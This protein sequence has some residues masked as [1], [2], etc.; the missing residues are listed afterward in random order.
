MFGSP[1]LDVAIGMVFVYL[2]LS[3]ICS[4]ANELIEL[5][6][7]GRA[8]QLEEG[9]RELLQRET[10]ENVIQRLYH[11]LGGIF[12]RVYYYVTGKTNTTKED[13]LVARIYDHPL[14]NSLFKG[15]YE[16]NSRKLPSYIPATNFALA[17]MD[18]VPT[19][20][21][22]EATRPEDEHTNGKRVAAVVTTSGAAYATASPPPA[23]AS[24]QVVVSVAGT[25]A[26]ESVPQQKTGVTTSTTDVSSSTPGDPLRTLR[27]ALQSDALQELPYQKARDA[28]LPLVAAAGNDAV[29]A[30]QNIEDWYNASMDRVSGWYKRRAHKFLLLIGFIAAVLL[31]ADSLAI[32]RALNSD[33]SLREVV[34]AQ[35]TQYIK[36]AASPTPTPAASDGAKPAAETTASTPVTKPTPPKSKP[37]PTPT[38][39]LTPTPTPE[40]SNI[41]TASATP[42][43]KPTPTPTPSICDKEPDSPQCKYE[44][45]LKTIES[46]GLPIG[47]DATDVNR[48]WPGSRV[49]QPAIFSAWKKQIRL[50]WIGWFLTAFAISLGAPFWFDMLNKFIVVRS[51][52]K[53]KEKS[54]DEPSKS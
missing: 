13:T 36:E 3:L 28:L 51:T 1:I 15:A 30:R 11:S 23:P 42:A 8:S 47:W 34:V 19:I 52:V 7:K 40:Q 4:A 49:W 29:K 46:L 2:L 22:G 18:L 50:H 48:T 16:P 31:N 35:A 9:L 54:Q 21:A 45:S 20:S 26:S 10:T 14:V 25:P 33:K 41:A 38:P 24:P 43:G 44:K 6:L 5:F 12:G 37:T 17:L 39:T 53:P 32:V 27:E